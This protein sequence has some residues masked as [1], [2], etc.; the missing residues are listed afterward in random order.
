MKHRYRKGFDHEFEARETA[1]GFAMM[2]D[3]HPSGSVDVSVSHVEGRHWVYI[4]FEGEYD[5]NEL[6]AATGYMKIG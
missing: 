5:A 4:A 2:P 6:F 3:V 1:N